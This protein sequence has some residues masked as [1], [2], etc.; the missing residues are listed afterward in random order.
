M[1]FGQELTVKQRP[2]NYLEGLRSRA[3]IQKQGWGGSD[4]GKCLL[5]DQPYQF[6]LFPIVYAFCNKLPYY[7]FCLQTQLFQKISF[8]INN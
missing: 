4:I 6:I 1:A 2:G 5:T 7:N 8:Q 3:C